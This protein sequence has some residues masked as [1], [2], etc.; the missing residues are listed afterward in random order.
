M[1]STRKKLSLAEARRIALTAQGFAEPRPTGRIDKRH[2]RKTI[3]RM[4]LL[5]V[6][7]VNV[8][9]RSEELPLFARLGPHPRHLVREMDGAGELFEY[10]LHEA[11]LLPAW[12][13]PLVRWKKERALSGQ[14]A[15]VW[16][17]LRAYHHEHPEVVEAVFNEI[18]ARGPVRPSELSMAG[19]KN[20][21]G[22]GWHW[23]TAKYAVEN[24]FWTGRVAAAH[25]GPGFERAYDVPENCFA[26]SVLEMPAPNEHEARKQLLLMAARSHGIG[27]AK[28]LADYYRFKM[29]TARPLLAELVEEGALTTVDVE[30]WADGLYLDPAAKKPRVVPARA[31]L[32]PF[33]PVVW[34]RTRAEKLFGFHYRIEIYVPKEKR[35]HGYYVLPFLLGD[36]LVARVDLKA[37]RAAGTLLVQSAWGEVGI[38]EADVAGE[39]AEELRLMASWLEFDAVKVV[40][41]G[42]LAPTL[43]KQFKAE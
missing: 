20:R 4:G 27:T 26:A 40:R 17:G 15:S 9:V 10:W 33:D 1:P 3:D 39:L 30:G 32:S 12:M 11:S 22:W 41:K 31:L 19:G 38:N 34:E 16:G 13:E 29:P 28:C 43:V 36:Q 23:D 35:V 21:D 37:D 14:D 5:Q 2:I 6:D 24:L 25:R 42:D 18:A 8:L 7:S